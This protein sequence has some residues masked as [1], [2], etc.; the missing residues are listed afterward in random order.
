M[1]HPPAYFFS[2]DP[3]SFGVNVKLEELV[4][5]VKE[6]F[7]VG[8]HLD[9]DKILFD[10]PLCRLLHFRHHEIFFEGEKGGKR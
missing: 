9:H 8:S 4:D 10:L 7:E 1:S 2:I 6:L 3:G 5:R